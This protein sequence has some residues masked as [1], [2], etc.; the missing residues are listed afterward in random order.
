MQQ[1]RAFGIGEGIQQVGGHLERSRGRRVEVVLKAQGINER[2]AAGLGIETLAIQIGD[3][4]FIV[5]IVARGN[6]RL[7]LAMGAKNLHG[8]L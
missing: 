1:R 4:F 2:R 6:P 5:H 7:L 3:R 8:G